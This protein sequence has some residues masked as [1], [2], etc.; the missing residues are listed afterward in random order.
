MEVGYAAWM[1]LDLDRTL[2]TRAQIDARIG[3]LAGDLDRALHGVTDR[4]ESV[5]MVAVMTGALVF[6]ADL[7]R[8]LPLKMSLHLVSA[9]SYP[10][11]ATE[12]VGE[13]VVG[14]LG[15]SGGPSDLAGRH[16]LVV[17]DIL[18]SGRTLRA[19]TRM[20]KEAE[21][22]SV[23]TVVLLDKAERRAVEFEADHVGFAIPDEFVVG[24]GL[25][26]DG[27]YRNVPEICTLRREVIDGGSAGGGA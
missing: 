2:V 11:P 12:S 25:D 6:A 4:G 14:W 5:A 18:D 22:A 7:I 24:Y 10:G 26:Y 3:E 1:K 15:S 19:V 27:Y 13:P 20:V 9:S 16:V 8:R 23:Q 21:P 17:D